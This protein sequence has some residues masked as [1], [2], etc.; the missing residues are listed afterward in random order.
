M[1]LNCVLD[2]GICVVLHGCLSIIL[3]VKLIEVLLEFSTTREIGFVHIA[4]DNP[5]VIESTRDGVLVGVY[6]LIDH[7]EK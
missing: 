1:Q 3:L 7:V 4:V 6:K 2:V 5:L